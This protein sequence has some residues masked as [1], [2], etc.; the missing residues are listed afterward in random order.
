[1]VLVFDS[2]PQLRELRQGKH[3]PSVHVGRSAQRFELER[4]ARVCGCVVG[5]RVAAVMRVWA[6]V[7]ADTHR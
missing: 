2:G 6:S 4:N 7:R 1:M 5:D 3:V